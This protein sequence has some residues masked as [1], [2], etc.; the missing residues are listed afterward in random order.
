MDILRFNYHYKFEIELSILT[1]L[2]QKKKTNMLTIKV[3][4]FS[5]VVNLCSWNQVSCYFLIILL[6]STLF[7]QM[8]VLNVI[9]LAPF[10]CKCLKVLVQIPLINERLFYNYFFRLSVGNSFATYGHTRPYLL[11]FSFCFN[12]EF[13]NVS[14]NFSMI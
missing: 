11:S 1:D 12:I 14:S 7:F 3:Q 9:F 4:Y 2:N 6:L 8:S 5:F 13:V 10:Q